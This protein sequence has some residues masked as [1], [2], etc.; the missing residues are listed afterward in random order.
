[1]QKYSFGAYWTGWAFGG[2][3]TDNKTI[4][5]FI[6]WM[7]AAWQIAKDKAKRTWAIIASAVLLAVYLI[8]HS[9]LGSELDYR[10]MEKHKMETIENKKTED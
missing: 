6:V 7:I 9:L 2:D 1:M 3:L 5:A 10:K 8:P 4:V